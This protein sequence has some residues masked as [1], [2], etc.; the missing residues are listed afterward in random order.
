M[1]LN[2]TS[3]NINFS[4]GLDTKSDPFQV[5]PGKF[6]ALQNTVF[7]KGG[8]L[9]K[10]NGYGM[11]T[12]LPDATSTYVTTF[13]GNLTAIGKSIR[14][15]STGASQWVDKGQ[16]QPASLDTLPL[17]RNAT[18][19]SQC[20]AATHTNGLTCVVYTDNITSG[21]GTTAPS[22]KYAVVD[23]T[24][25]QNVVAPTAIP[26]TT[27][28]VNQPPKVFVL[29]NY[30]VIVFTNLIT[31]TN[32]LQYV[33][34]NAYSP[35]VRT[36]NVDL[37]SQYSA[38]SADAAPKFAGV[39]A[40]GNLY[41][42]WNGTDGG[43]AIRMLYLDSTLVAHSS[44]VAQASVTGDILSVC[45][46][47][48]G[49]NPVIY[50]TAY[51]SGTTSAKTFV[52]NQNLTVITAATTTISATTVLNIASTAQN[53]SVSIYY[54]KSQAYSY[55][56]GIPTNNIKTVAM[57][58]AGSV[59][60]VTT[61]LRSVGLASKAFL[62]DGISYMLAT[63]QSAYQPSYFLIN[64]S[65]QVIAKLAYANGGGYCTRGLASA[66]VRN[67]AVEVAYLVKDQI[68]SVNKT[69]GVTAVGGIYAQTGINLARVTLDTVPSSSAEIGGSLNVSGGILWSYD[70]YAAVESGFNLWPDSV[71]ATTATTGG[72]MVKQQYYYVATY[73]WTDN[74]GNIHRSAPSI[75]LSVNLSGS[76]T[77]TNKATVNVPTLR[78]TYKTA[79]PVK[80]VI[81]RW[82]TAQQTYYQVTS[83][84][85]P[86]LNDT[87]VDSVSFVDTQAD[88][89][90]LGNSI[91][92][93]T[94]GVIENIAPPSVKNTCLFQ[95][96][97]F[98]INAEDQNQLGYSKVVIE[99]TPVETSDLF[100]VYVAPTTSAEGSTGVMRC[101]APMDD[102]LI[103]FKDSAAYYL[104]GQGPDNTGSNNNFGEP[105]FITSTV[106]C[107]NQASI[108]FIPQGLMFQSQKGIW[109][110]GRDLNTTY[111]GAPVEE[112]TRGATVQSAVNIPGSN[113][114]RFTLDT[115]V[116]L[117][118]DYFYGQWGT[119][120]N[121]PAVSATLYGSVHTYI[122]SFGQVYQETPGVYLDGSRPVLMSFT[123]S[124]L[125]LAGLQGYER[126][127]Y[128]Y[129]LGVYLSP[130]KLNVQIAYDYN[131]SPT[132]SVTITPDN[133]TAKWGGESVWGGGAGWG[134]NG[135]V[136]QWRVFLAQQKCQAFQ[137]TIAELFDSTLGQTAG[138]GLTLSGLDV[139][140]GLK[141]Q[142]PRIKSARSVG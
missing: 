71:E 18:N 47:I 91:L 35:S 106:G 140:V 42:A 94:G 50:V 127:Y 103:I 46:D 36:T 8:Q 63:Y 55:D 128:F 27:G 95:S 96:R 34:L 101:I 108:V 132:Q 57:T 28:A 110:L 88:S 45:A 51:A 75:P 125:N 90:I 61:I 16:L 117:M 37:S 65:G 56:S 81:Y 60:S 118:F 70:G 49:N 105:T 26:V 22:Y 69:Q 120:T 30:F 99:N 74:Q 38:G 97:L 72:S 123:T 85:A 15:Y 21:A 3:L 13:N 111:I 93:T 29:G 137:I 41:L 112:F 126:A 67:G 52:V 87:T 135:N 107:N 83:L 54:E 82:S 19:Q 5:G 78:I 59:G 73:E 77:D 53:G 122:N 64:Q 32:H 4:Q 76:G 40:N 84:S 138:A 1:A 17:I 109:L 142:Y 43:G 130:H 62:Y 80:I 24:T 44:G 116:T 98:Y 141:S 11:L 23:S 86:L 136:E 124:W 12:A 48:T 20:D 133:Y 100:T 121:V 129:L 2:K 119:F 9:K 33:A 114:V 68:T 92:Y 113:Q 104:N 39:V 66:L 6:L 14:A 31:A 58:Q 134:G 79:N 10:R 131:S 89:A 115:G 7:D 102:K 25:G 139:V